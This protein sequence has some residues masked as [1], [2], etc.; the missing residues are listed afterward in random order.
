MEDETLLI[1]E[2]RSLRRLFGYML[3]SLLALQNIR[4]TL[5]PSRTPPG[6]LLNL[7]TPEGQA[8]ARDAFQGAVALVTFAM[9]EFPGAP[10]KAPWV[11]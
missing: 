4:L 5:D 6:P 9:K 10:D 8:K 1:D 3:W 7:D 2:L 11:M